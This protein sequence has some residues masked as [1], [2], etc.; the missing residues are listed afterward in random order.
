MQSASTAVA[1]VAACSL[2]VSG[3]CRSS[4]VPAEALRSTRIGIRESSPARGE[5]ALPL[6]A[7]SVRFAV[8]GDSGRGDQPQ[9]E[10]A[11]QMTAWHEKFPFEFVVMLGDNLYPPHGPDDFTTK[12][13]QPYRALLERGVTFHAAIGNHDLDCAARLFPLAHQS[14]LM[15]ASFLRAD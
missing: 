8:I 1:L 13:E 15:Q 2:L 7:G 5:L 6:K 10:V 11:Q 4:S 14:M 9:A 3:G 12:F